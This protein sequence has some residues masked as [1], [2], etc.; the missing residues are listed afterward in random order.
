MN[1]KKKDS[2]TFKSLVCFSL[3]SLNDMHAFCILWIHYFEYELG[4]PVSQWIYCPADLRS[5]VLIPAG[6]WNSPNHCTQPFIITFPSPWDDWYAVKQD[7]TFRPIME[8][9][10]RLLGENMK[11]K[12][13]FPVSNGR[14]TWEC[15]HTLLSLS[16]PWAYETEFKNAVSTF[17]ARYVYCSLYIQILSL[18]QTSGKPVLEEFLIHVTLVFSFSQH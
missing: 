4:D 18:W 2:L 3:L 10:T 6:D 1:Q 8:V 15:A 13:H 16:S 7:V 9:Y 12:Q 11:S 14:K 5:R 17:C